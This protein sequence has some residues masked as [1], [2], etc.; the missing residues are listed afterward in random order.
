MQP[1][2]YPVLRDDST[3]ENLPPKEDNPLE[4]L[5]TRDVTGARDSPAPAGAPLPGSKWEVLGSSVKLGRAETTKLP[6]AASG[7]H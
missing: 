5:P 6:K 3:E 2:S 1:L 4:H 7:W